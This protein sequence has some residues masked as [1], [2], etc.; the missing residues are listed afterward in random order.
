MA[1]LGASGAALGTD[2]PQQAEDE[3]IVIAARMK[4]I[5]IE[6][7]LR[8]PWLKACN[9]DGTTGT[10]AADRRPGDLHIIAAMPA[11]REDK[12]RRGQAMRQCPD[13]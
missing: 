9:L 12:A 2:T 10:P 3:I 5:N 8:G 4:I 13:R 7:A 11:R 6:Y 1:L